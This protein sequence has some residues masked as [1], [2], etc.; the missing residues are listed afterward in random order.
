[1]KA[2]LSQL[3]RIDPSRNYG[4]KASDNALLLTVLV[5]DTTPRIL[6]I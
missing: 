5:L 4:A 2:W 1:M 3:G 6:N